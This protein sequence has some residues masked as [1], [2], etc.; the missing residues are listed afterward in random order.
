[1]RA[2]QHRHPPVLIGHRFQKTVIYVWDWQ[3]CME[4]ASMY[5]T[6]KLVLSH[7]EKF[8]KEGF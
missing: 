2:D 3:V 6:G 5:G 4:P 8:L 7:H 1:V